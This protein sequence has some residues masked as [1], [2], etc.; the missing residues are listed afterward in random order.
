[1]RYSTST[2]LHVRSLQRALSGVPLILEVNS[3]GS[4]R[5]GALRFLDRLML[6]SA[7]VVIAISEALGTHLRAVAPH[8]PVEVV[9]NAI[10][11]GRIPSELLESNVPPTDAINITYAGLLKPD[12]GLETAIHAAD[13]L[14]RAGTNV[15]FRIIG[16][17]PFLSRLQAFA[18]ER[19][20]IQLIGPVDFRDV[21]AFLAESHI[22]LYPTSHF[23]SFQSPT[24]LFEYMLARRPIVAASTPQTRQ[25]LHDGELG[26]LYEIDDSA[27]L[28]AHIHEVVDSKEMA[29][30]K[31]IAA[32]D[33]VLA[34]HTWRDRVMR[35]LQAYSDAPKNRGAGR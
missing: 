32:R 24:K 34:K 1:M 23:N 10:D 21:P 14:A 35:I 6:E 5:I 20:W 11:P 9:P 25:V 17:G 30:S 19:P 3:V 2:V 31:A 12:Y 27:G 26:F 15:K 29:L 8:V 13:I 22:L 7:T 16:D 4:Q 18:A 28:A 33:E